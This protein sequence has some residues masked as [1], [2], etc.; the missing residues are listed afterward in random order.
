[1]PRAGA[2]CCNSCMRGAMAITMTLWRRRR[3]RSPI[4]ARIFRDELSDEEILQ[5]IADFAQRRA[6]IA[7]AAGYDGVELMGSEGYLV[8]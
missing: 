7:K 6:S 1:M 2:S 4:N 3:S 8:N 5:T